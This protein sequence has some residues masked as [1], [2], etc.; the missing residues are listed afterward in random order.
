MEDKPSFFPATSMPEFTLE[1]SR[2]GKTRRLLLD[3]RR[4]TIGR[5]PSAGIPLADRSVS[6]FHVEIERSSRGYTFRDLG[7]SNGTLLNGQER[8][9]GKLRTGD[10]LQVG[11][12]RI[13]VN[14]DPVVLEEELPAAV[15]P[16]P[17]TSPE[18]PE[19]RE[20]ATAPDPEVEEP[21]SSRQSTILLVVSLSTAFVGIALGLGLV[22]LLHSSPGTGESSETTSLSPSTGPTGT[23]GADPDAGSAD[24]ATLEPG[25][26]P[27]TPAAEVVPTPV[28][29]L[30]FPGLASDP[31]GPYPDRPTALRT[32]YRLS[33]DLLGRPPTR[34][35]I[36][37]LGSP[38]HLEVW[39]SV[40]QRMTESPP[41]QLGL[42]QIFSRLLARRPEPDELD[43][44]RGWS[45]EAMRELGCYLSATSEY[46]APSFRRPRDLGQLARSLLV[47]LT[48]ELPPSPGVAR[49]VERALLESP[50]L[51]EVAR[52]LAL[53][54]D[55]LE[56]PPSGPEDEVFRFLGRL[57]DAGRLRRLEEELDGE[58]TSWAWLRLALVS[59]PDYRSY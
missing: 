16:V 1:H 56:I 51:E 38:T 10:V 46:R 58:P 55:S 40:R 48:G 3:D 57:P 12:V 42:T 45:F 2:S 19:E 13:T 34:E 50:G 39:E 36:A 37:S 27:G 31:L 43:H 23:D 47:D 22:M 29:P 32:I 4:I 33:L 35:E 44:L 11:L 7:S 21:A 28:S 14:L 5:S 41:E 17:E 53:G 15:P 30:E 54:P 52:I 20:P 6:K 25:T 8:R 18:A 49:D 24:L 26:E 59:T 9:S